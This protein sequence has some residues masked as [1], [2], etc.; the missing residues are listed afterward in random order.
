MTP[1]SGLDVYAASVAAAYPEVFGQDNM[2]WEEK[3][4][5]LLDEGNPT[6]LSDHE[7]YDVAPGNIWA[8][9]KEATTPSPEEVK[10]WSDE[11]KQ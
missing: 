2:A 8:K 4:L 3:L 7:L 11:L 6:K 5:K 9:S 10:E 1:S